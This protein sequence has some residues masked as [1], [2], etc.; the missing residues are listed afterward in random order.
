MNV[1]QLIEHYGTQAAAAVAIKVSPQAVS[2]W[3]SGGIPLD[4]QI[5]WE[6]QSGGAL[7][8]DLPAEVRNNTMAV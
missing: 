8:A 5:K 6:V 1:E 2:K 4:F 7:R 3:K